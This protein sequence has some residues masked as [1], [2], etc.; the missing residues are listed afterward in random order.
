MS[1]N[2]ISAIYYEGENPYFLADYA[3]A[4]PEPAG[5]AISLFIVE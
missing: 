1:I 5:R 3:D 2:D 4:V